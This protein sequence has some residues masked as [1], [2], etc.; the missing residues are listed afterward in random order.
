MRTPGCR[1]QNRANCESIYVSPSRRAA[2]ESRKRNTPAI[3]RRRAAK[4]QTSEALGF[5]PLLPWPSLRL[6]MSFAQCRPAAFSSGI[7]GGQ[8]GS[9]S[10]RVSMI[11]LMV[12][13]HMLTRFEA[14]HGGVYGSREHRFRTV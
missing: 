13:A 2:Q 12:H 1:R 6:L 4:G 7:H 5:K 10:R 9:W 3:D 8:S 14:A 11:L